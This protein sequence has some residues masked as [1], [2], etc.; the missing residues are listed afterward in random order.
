[1]P[2]NIAPS[3]YKLQDFILNLLFPHHCIGC[4]KER[5][6]LCSACREGLP[7]LQPPYCHLC[8]QP[9]R[10]R[11]LCLRCQRAPLKID[12]IRSPFVF[13]GTIRNAIHSL[14]Y[15][16][17]RALA[18]P[19]S[20]LLWEHLMTETTTYDILV[21]VPLHPARVRERGYNQSALLARELGKK[22]QLPTNEKA[23]LRIKDSLPQAKARSADERMRNVMDAFAC[24][25]NE[26]SGLRVL[27]LDDVCTTGATLEACAIALKKAGASSVWGLTLARET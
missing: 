16:K 9:T 13:Q 7:R 26:F 22:A 19:L 20:E 4:S 12:G 14:K 18:V 3:L 21:P 23:L 25:G 11:G 24:T 27:L 1:M 17:L 6:L 8:G 15:R 5:T 10:Q 2:G